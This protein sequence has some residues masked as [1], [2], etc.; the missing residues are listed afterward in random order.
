MDRRMD[1]FEKK[2]EERMEEGSSAVRCTAEVELYGMGCVGAC[3]NLLPFSQLRVVG[4]FGLAI[5]HSQPWPRI[6]SY[7]RTNAHVPLQHLL[8]SCN[9]TLCYTARHH[10]SPHI[11]AG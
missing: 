7:V 11:R 3:V 6:L 10:L 1:A 2:G 5:P 4:R 9:P 8:E